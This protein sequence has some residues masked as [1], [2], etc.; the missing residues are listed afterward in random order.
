[1]EE[2]GKGK[3]GVGMQGE[4]RVGEERMG[5]AMGKEVGERG[6]EVV[7]IWPYQGPW[8]FGKA[9]HAGYLQC[10]PPGGQLPSQQGWCQQGQ[11][12]PRELT[13]EVYIQITP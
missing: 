6:W 11:E 7:V 4:E 3:E 5:E 1:M 13:K 10:L 8:F 9:P 2:E 12:E